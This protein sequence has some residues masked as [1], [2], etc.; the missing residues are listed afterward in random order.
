MDTQDAAVR[1]SVP[2]DFKVDAPNVQRTTAK[3]VFDCDDDGR[4]PRRHG[5]NSLD[6]LEDTSAVW[7]SSRSTIDFVESARRI[8][9]NLNI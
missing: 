4:Y 9:T 6:E 3:D 5:K 7:P 8:A 1:Q 2:Q